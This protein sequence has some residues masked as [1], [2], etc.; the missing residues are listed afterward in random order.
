[1]TKQRPPL[2]PDCWGSKWDGKPKNCVGCTFDYS[3]TRNSDPAAQHVPPPPTSANDEQAGGDHYK[4][5][6]VQPWDVVDMWPL[7]ERVAYYRGNALKYIMRLNDKDTPLTNAEKAAHYCR[8]LV[9][10]LRA[11]PVLNTFDLRG[12][13]TTDRLITEINK[14]RDRDDGLEPA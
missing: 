11:Q 4:R 2:S 6:K 8:K 14:I 7:A 12:A 3:C 10:V 1:M 9:E 13:V 5:M